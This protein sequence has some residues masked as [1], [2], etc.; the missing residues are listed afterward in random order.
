MG[1]REEGREGGRKGRVTF[2][3]LPHPGNYFGRLFKQNLGAGILYRLFRYVYRFSSAPLDL[4]RHCFRSAAWLRTG[5]MTVRR[6]RD[7]VRR[8]T[9]ACL[10]RRST[11][12]HKMRHW[13]AK[14]RQ[15]MWL[16][17]GHFGASP[18]IKTL[19]IFRTI[20]VGSGSIFLVILG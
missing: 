14:E 3:M 4:V 5:M 15:I 19:S 11:G 2:Q 12:M 8:R 1:C 20:S 10:A 18:E 17:S 16:D 13:L 9:G 7:G 6:G